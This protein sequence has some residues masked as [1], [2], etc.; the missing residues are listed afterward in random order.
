M[1]KSSIKYFIVCAIVIWCMFWLVSFGLDYLLGIKPLLWFIVGLV[2]SFIIFLFAASFFCAKVVYPI[3]KQ[4]S[5]TILSN[6]IFGLGVAFLIYKIYF[7]WS[8]LDIS[9]STQLTIGIFGTICFAW[10]YY[11]SIIDPISLSQ[12]TNKN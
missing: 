9:N 2:V 6:V 5:K 8:K 1:V 3:A 7:L 12:R 11:K 10:T 4:N